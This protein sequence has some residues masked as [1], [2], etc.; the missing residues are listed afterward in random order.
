LDLLIGEELFEVYLFYKLA[1][2]KR[3]AGE[4]PTVWP[5][6]FDVG[7]SSLVVNAEEED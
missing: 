5:I 2:V 4:K 7:A 1:F 3:E 6:A